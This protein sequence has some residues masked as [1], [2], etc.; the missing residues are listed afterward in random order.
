M[1]KQ[2]LHLFSGQKKAEDFYDAQKM[3][4]DFS[5]GTVVVSDKVQNCR[6]N[7]VVGNCAVIALIK[8]ALV[9]F[10]SLEKI[11][12]T[13]EIVDGVVF[14]KFSD[15]TS[16]QLTKEEI[17]LTIRL[18]GLNVVPNPEYDHT[19]IV[20]YA[21]ICKR[22]FRLKRKYSRK[23]IHNFQDAIE[24]INCGYDTGEVYKLLA[25][26]KKEV[27]PE[28][29]EKYK[30]VVIWNKVHASYCTYGVQDILGAEYKIRHSWMMN[31][32]GAG[33]SIQGAYIL[34]S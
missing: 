32:L 11:F 31:P 6:G 3:I 9:E 19:A 33:G 34:K 8:T 16:V 27:K 4:T 12:K 1:F 24:F 18:A 28:H 5:Q 30:A 2:L 14:A 10:Q 22:V 25:L 17:D 7:E 20:L 21:L 13:F 26:K 23:C 15:G 29:L